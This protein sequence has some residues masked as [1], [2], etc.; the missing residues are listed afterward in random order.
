[1]GVAYYIA[2]DDEELDVG[3]VNGKCVA[4]AMDELTAL[5]EELGVAPLESFM[6]Q[7]ADEFADMIDEEIEMEDGVDGDAVWFEPADGMAAIDALIAALSSEPERV[8]DTAGVLED[9]ADYRNALENADAAGAKW[10]LAI[11]I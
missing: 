10:H 8:E 11:D 5:A 1:M 4:R 2:V 3:D 7:S 6:G 9:L